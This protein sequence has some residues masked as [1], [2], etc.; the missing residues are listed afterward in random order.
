MVNKEIHKNKHS[1]DMTW[2]RNQIAVWFSLHEPVLIYGS[3]H[4][5]VFKSPL[6]RVHNEHESESG[7]GSPVAGFGSHRTNLKCCSTQPT[8]TN[9]YKYTLN[10][11]TSIRTHTRI[12]THVHIQTY[13]TLSIYTYIH[14]HHLLNHAHALHTKSCIYIV[15]QRHWRTHTLACMHINPCNH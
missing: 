15:H 13:T 6:Y 10:T 12:P 3:S 5:T 14:I 1:H 4:G 9:K 7:P 8:H 2:F 11:H